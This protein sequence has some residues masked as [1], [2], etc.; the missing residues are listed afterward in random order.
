MQ[1][2]PLVE[3]LR[4]TVAGQS[5]PSVRKFQ[6]SVTTSDRTYSQTAFFSVVRVG[7]NEYRYLDYTKVTRALQR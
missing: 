2:R 4:V 5:T 3:A 1:G 7:A 6:Q